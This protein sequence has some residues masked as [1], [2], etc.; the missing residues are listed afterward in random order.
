MLDKNS[1]TVVSFVERWV[2]MIILKGSTKKGQD[3]VAKGTKWIGNDLHQVYDS[4]S[5][6]KQRAFE[7]CYEKYLATPEHSAWGICSKNT[8]M[9]TVSWVG[10]FDGENAMF[11]ETNKHSY[12]VLLDK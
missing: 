7:W 6:A 3:I 9:F 4:W 2:N 11:Y 5:D 12:V 10:L 1:K 8:N